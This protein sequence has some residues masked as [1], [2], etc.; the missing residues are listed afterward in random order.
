LD[1]TLAPEPPP[2]ELQRFQVRQVPHIRSRGSVA[3]FELWEP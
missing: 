2:P 1:V 3:G